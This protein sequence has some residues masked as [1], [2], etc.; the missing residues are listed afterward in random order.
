MANRNL[1]DETIEVLKRHNK[2]HLDVYFV[3]DSLYCATWNDFSDAARNINYDPGYGSVEI[4][5]FLKVVGADWWLERH[6]YDGAEWWEYKTM[7]K[8]GLFNPSEVQYL[9]SD[10]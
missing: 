9:Y 10:D 6:E 1:L 5:P 2:T 8:T 4:N 7:P 3:A